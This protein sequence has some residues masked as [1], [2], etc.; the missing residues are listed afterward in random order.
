ALTNG[1]LRT[2]GSNGNGEL[3]LGFASTTPQLTPQTVTGIS[4]VKAG[5]GV[6]A[7]GLG[8]ALALRTGGGTP[9]VAAWGANNLSQL[10]D[11]ATTNR[12][13]P[14]SV[15]LTALGLPAGY[16][17]VTLAAGVFHS[18]LIYRPSGNDDSTNRVAT[19][20]SNFA[21]E[22]GNGTTGTAVV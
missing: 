2:W 13:S 20:G 12:P 18:A 8:H 17:L 10:G 15:D 22:L 19:W 14:V 5:A 6:V 16:T 9:A 7:A 1:T 21:G 4:D 3:G 11:G